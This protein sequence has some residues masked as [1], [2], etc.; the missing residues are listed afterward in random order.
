VL[1]WCLNAQRLKQSG[2]IIFDAWSKDIDRMFEGTSPLK[3]DSLVVVG[4]AMLLYGLSLKNLLRGLVTEV[5]PE[6]LL[7]MKLRSW[8]ESELNLGKLFK[9][10]GIR[11]EKE[12][13]D[14][15]NRLTAFLEWA[16]CYPVYKSV[17]MMGLPPLRVSPAT[18]AP[19][20]PI[21]TQ[22]RAILDKLYG[23]LKAK[24]ASN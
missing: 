9:E 12:E 3:L 2:D 8:S 14:L 23:R 16:E 1:F 24:L 18:P 7:D 4:C 10:A 6:S 11:L 19:P 22:K 21:P 15:V 17:E 5:N 20:L 13:N